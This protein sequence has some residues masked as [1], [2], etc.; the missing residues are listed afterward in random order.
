MFLSLGLILSGGLLGGWICSR[1]KLPAL[2]GM[3]GA[4]ILLGP[5]VFHV[6]DEQMMAIS[7]DLRKIALLIIL[8]RAGLSLHFDD[9]RR[10]GLPA[11][12][13]SFVPACCEI[14]GMALLAPVFLGLDWIN[15]CLL[16]TVIAA[17]SPAVIVPRM[18]RLMEQ[19]YGTGQSVPQ[20][21]LAGASLDD[22]FVIVLFSVFSTM[23][24]NG[25]FEA[26]MLL[27]IPLSVFS[28]IGIGL[29]AGFGLG[30]FYR[31][32]SCRPVVMVMQFYAITFLLT[33]LETVVSETLPFSSLLAVMTMAM[34]LA[35]MAPDPAAAIL[36]AS[37]TLW[38][39]AEIFLFVLVGAEVSLPYAARLGLS[40]VVLLVLVLFFRMAG[41]ALALLPS[42]LDGK[43]RLFCLMAYTPKAT[44]QAA[45]GAVPLAMGLSSGQTIL[46][47]AV[48]AILLTAPLG[49]W[50]ID[51]SAS[52]LLKR[53]V[54][55]S[56]ANN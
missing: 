47:M 37:N 53:K 26:G 6:L 33:A 51:L 54:S 10:A 19:G 39:C 49:A 7:A 35:Q 17:V 16:G 8:S 22:I 5:F 12:L 21:I 3:L 23:A 40:G 30:K 9:L 34:L 52:R 48:L 29:L 55:P 44:V 36:K 27:E 15:A 20:M 25:Q 18:L 32:I 24:V 38:S 28:G 42:H 41:T 4:G 45:I 56:S 46:T 50:A 2:S 43:S 14:F 11:F 13:L 31:R 1:L